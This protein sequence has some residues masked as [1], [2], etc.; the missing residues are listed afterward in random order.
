MAVRMSDLLTTQLSRL[1]YEPTRKRVRALLGDTTVVDSDR[2]V[3][4]WEPRRVVPGYAVPAED[5]R[6]EV[7]DPSAV[8]EASEAS[9]APGAPDSADGGFVVGG[10]DYSRY[11][12]WDPRTPFAVRETPGRPVVVRSAADGRT[13]PGFLPDDESLAGMVILDFPSFDTWIEDDERIVSHPHDPY[14]RIDIRATSKRITIALDG[15]V[16]ADSTGAH[17]LYETGLP[18]RYYL[19]RHDVQADLVDSATSTVCAYKGTATYY[20]PV[21]NGT[22]VPDLA[23]SYHEP[24]VDALGVRDLVCFFTER[25]DLSIDGVRQSRPWTPWS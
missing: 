7:I 25:M 9:V 17:I 23:W 14:A 18:P 1:R 8:S 6:G 5:I 22:A 2:A 20:S 4:V 15:Q 12:Y 24:L 16:L 21:V 3:L 19:P 10:R 13:V 11:P